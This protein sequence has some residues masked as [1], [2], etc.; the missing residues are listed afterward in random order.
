MNRKK[1]TTMKRFLLPHAFQKVGWWLLL[2]SLVAG[3]AALVLDT[4]SGPL[5]D[6]AVT[7]LRDLVAL[8]KKRLPEYAALC[9]ANPIFKGRLKNVGHLDLAGVLEVTDAAYQWL[10]VPY[11]MTMGLISLAVAFGVA[12]AYTENLGMQG[13]M[14]NGFVALFL[15]LMVSSPAES[16]TLADGTTKTVLDTTYLGGTGMFCAL[17]LPIIVVRIIKL[18][19]DRHIDDAL[20][21]RLTYVLIGICGLMNVF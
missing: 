12:Y 3:A 9:N 17:I 19:A 4:I 7:Q 11:N 6:G 21:R 20:L 18:C 1:Q 8:L 13:A 14:A 15:F 2:A 10:Q 5:P 16:V